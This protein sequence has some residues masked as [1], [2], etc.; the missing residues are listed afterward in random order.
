MISIGCF[1]SDNG[2][3]VAWKGQSWTTRAHGTFGGSDI[4]TATKVDSF[5][6]ARFYIQLNE[7]IT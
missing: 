2:A 4:R 5:D 3:F 7:G 1:L 6:A